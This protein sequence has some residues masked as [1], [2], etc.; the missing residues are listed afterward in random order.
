MCKNIAVGE[1]T[2]KN[3]ISKYYACIVIRITPDFLIESHDCLTRNT[4]IKRDPLVM[5][6]WTDEQWQLMNEEQE[7]R[8][9]MNEE[10]EQR[11]L[12]NE[13]QAESVKIAIENKFQLI[14]GPPG[15]SL[16]NTFKNTSKTV[17]SKIR[18]IDHLDALLINISFKHATHQPCVQNMKLFKTY[19]AS[20]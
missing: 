10:Q 20:R 12:M 18:K 17:L 5:K 11:Q 3:K 15:N 8:Q 7:Q 6:L 13:E 2:M 1:A 4:L 14:Q 19:I 16:Y 9:L